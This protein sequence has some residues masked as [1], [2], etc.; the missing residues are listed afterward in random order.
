[1]NDDTITIELAG[2]TRTIPLDDAIVLARTLNAAV[3]RH[4]NQRK[5]TTVEYHPIH[6]GYPDAATDSERADP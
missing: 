4:V 2:Q 1:M 5:L 3:S 6:G